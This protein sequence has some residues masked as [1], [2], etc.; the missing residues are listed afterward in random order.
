M[1]DQK[2]R[3]TKKKTV[4]YVWPFVFLCSSEDAN[5][6]YKVIASCAVNVP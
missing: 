1:I 3:R 5:S 4:N 6:V 2:M